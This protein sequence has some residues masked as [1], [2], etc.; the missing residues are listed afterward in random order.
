MKENLLIF[1][2][3]KGSSKYAQKAIMSKIAEKNNAELLS[4][5]NAPLTYKSGY[6]WFNKD[7]NKEVIKESFDSAIDYAKNILE[8]EISKL[9]YSWDKVILCGH[10]Q[11]GCIAIHLATLL[12]AKKA[13]NICGD[14]SYNFD[15]TDP[16]F[17]KEI[18]IIWIEAG[19]D[20]YISQERKDSYKLLLNA[21]YNLKYIV[22]KKSDHSNEEDSLDISI[23]EDTI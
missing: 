18:P 17:N 23:A 16:K 5:I 1:L 12:N 19:K 21:G 8:K 2:H 4:V 14:I 15:Y 22:N 9:G 20:K 7:K 13:I 3:S 10:S 6:M 11:G